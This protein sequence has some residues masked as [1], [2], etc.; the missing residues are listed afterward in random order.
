MSLPCVNLTAFLCIWNRNTNSIPVR[1]LWLGPALAPCPCHHRS[2]SPLFLCSSLSGLY[3][4]WRSQCIP[5]SGHLHCLFLKLLCGS[6]FCYLG[7]VIWVPPSP[8]HLKLS[9]P[10]IHSLF[11]LPFCFLHR[12]I[13]FWNFL[14]YY[15][16]L[17]VFFNVKV[18]CVVHVCLACVC[19]N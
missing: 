17:L 7:F 14:V 18:A 3:V 15:S 9:L 19:L 5:T 8:L 1:V 11:H 2:L 13:S 12:R 6:S 4:P 10:S 16:C